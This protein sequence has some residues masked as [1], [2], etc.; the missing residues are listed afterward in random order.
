MAPPSDTTVLLW[1][2][3][4][5]S[6]RGPAATLSVDAIAKAGVAIADKH[7]LDALSMQAVAESL[8]FTKMSL[9]RHL[10]NK[11]E[12]IAVM[13]DL[14]VEDVPNLNPRH[15]WRR[16]LET[17]ASALT[18]VWSRHPW[19]S[20]ATRGT[21]VMGPREVSWVE[22]PLEPLADTR[23]TRAERLDAVFLIFGHLRNTQSTAGAG[24]Q[25]WHDPAMAELLDAHADRFPALN[26]LANTELSD[27]NGRSLGL[28]LILDGIQSLHDARD[29]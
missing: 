10:R 11:D 25:P 22:C 24:T 27:D 15:S 1:Q 4:P 23:L 17:F 14:A 8:G 20:W 16:R 29:S 18:D 12:L 19:L 26:G 28:Q 7:G 9:Y 2:G 3:R 5:P 21:R 6:R 13:I